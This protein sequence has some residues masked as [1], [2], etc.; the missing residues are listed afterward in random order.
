MRILDSQNTLVRSIPLPVPVERHA[1]YVRPRWSP[2]GSRLLIARV[3]PT[4]PSGS[5]DGV[6]EVGADGS[7]TVVDPRGGE[8]DWS[9]RGDVVLVRDGNLYVH[10]PGRSPRRLTW[11]GASHPSWSPDGRR[12]AFH[13]GCDGWLHRPQR[14]GCGVYVVP[15]KG[16]KAKLLVRRATE[17]VWSP[18][19]RRIAFVRARRIDPD[20]GFHD[21]QVLSVDPR[22][23]RLRLLVRGNTVGDYL[24]VS[25]PDWQVRP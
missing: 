12:I 6:F 25:S 7:L 19:G 23:R 1:R 17:P 13:R 2:D 11:R 3:A 20:G 16:G 18:D 21:A 5:D 22:G 24:D 14:R 10:T 15:A 8:P 4:P 9:V